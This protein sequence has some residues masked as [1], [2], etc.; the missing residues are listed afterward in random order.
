MIPG[1]GTAAKKEKRIRG[2]N[3]LF[4]CPV[5]MKNIYN[6]VSDCLEDLELEAHCDASV[7]EIHAQKYRVTFEERRNRNNKV[8]IEVEYCRG[9]NL[10]SS[11]FVTLDD[12]AWHEW[13]EIGIVERDGLS[14]MTASVLYE[15]LAFQIDETHFDSESEDDGETTVSQ[16]LTPQP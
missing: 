11:R 14:E 2:Q 12:D 13:I 1:T 3:P 8:V 9:L 5:R 6:A 16:P 4:P 15:G 7:A 10:A